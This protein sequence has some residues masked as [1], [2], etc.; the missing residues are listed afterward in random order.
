MSEL[1]T[2]RIR[3]TAAKLTLPHLAASL[4]E[5]VTRADDAQ[6]GYLDFL[7]MVLEEEQAIKEER[8]IWHALRVS[9]MPH[10]K[11]IEDFDFSYQPGLDVRKVA[12]VN[13]SRSR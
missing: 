7:D 4:G 2:A 12:M 10:H 13:R 11:T 8:R 9:G 5:F 3:A 6:M 1:V